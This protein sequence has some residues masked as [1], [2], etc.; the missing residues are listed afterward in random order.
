MKYSVKTL[1]S[2]GLEARWTHNRNG[3]PIIVA[4][5][6]RAPLT[7]QRSTWWHVTAGMWTSMQKDGVVEAF[8]NHTLLGDIFSIGV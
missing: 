7:H 6:L 4:R 5:N 1:R 2:A 3:A 8:D